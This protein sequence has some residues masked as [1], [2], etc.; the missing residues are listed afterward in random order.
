MKKLVLLLACAAMVA[1]AN[2]QQKL[3]DDVKGD[4]GGMSTNLKT[5]QDAL[6]KIQPAL[7]NA[8]SKDNAYTWFIAGRTGFG[9]YDKCMGEMA[10]GKTVDTQEMCDALLTGYDYF[11]KALVLDTIVQKDKTGQPILDKKTGAVKVKTKY[12]KDIVNAII[13]HI[14][15]F[16]NAGNGYYDKKDFK[17]AASTWA[18]FCDLAA[19]AAAGK[20]KLGY[21]IADST[22]A[23]I[24]F[25]EGVAAWQGDDLKGASA[26][27]AKARAK[28]Y[29]KKEIFDYAMSVAAGI[30]DND[31][32]VVA[33]AKEAYPIHGAADNTYARVIINDMLNNEK[34]DEAG[35]MLDDMI[36]SNPS[37]AETIDLKGI[38]LEQQKNVDEALTYF[39]KA[40]EADPEYAKANFDAGRM[41]FNKAVKAQEENPTLAGAKL[42]E[43]T[44]PFYRQAMP[45]LEKAHKLDPDNK[46][47][48]RALLNIYYQLNDDAKYEALEKE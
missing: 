25:Y 18:L 20:Y 12:S 33:I 14:N 29:L 44:G 5:F 26:A 32:E 40:I 27:F 45:L 43:I 7:E 37:N 13:G 2:A 30:P 8:E 3:V 6:K 41:Y 48:K 1:G 19:D 11:Q 21:E 15:D 36:A 38:L 22:V 35:K 23:E 46:D 4:I 31:A 47:C 42:L 24:R 34:F 17:K 16:K 28:G 9:L 39:L 10:I